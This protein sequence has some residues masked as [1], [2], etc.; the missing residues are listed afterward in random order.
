MW[1]HYGQLE[2]KTRLLFNLIVD[3]TGPANGVL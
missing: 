1:N 3:T 2:K